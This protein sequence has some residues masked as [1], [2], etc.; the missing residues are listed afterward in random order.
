[1]KKLKIFSTSHRNVNYLNDYY[2][3]VTMVGLGEE[4]FPDKWINSNINNEL[5]SK[6]FCYADLVGY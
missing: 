4:K 1:M 3:L 2:P 6:F 5:S